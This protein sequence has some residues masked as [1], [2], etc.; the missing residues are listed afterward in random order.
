[1]DMRTPSQPGSGSPPASVPDGL[2]RELMQVATEA[3]IVVDSSHDI[4]MFNHGAEGIF[5][6][7]ADE[8]L[9][10]PLDVLLPSNMIGRHR[11]LIE[12]FS[13][14]ESVARSMGERMV[15]RA[16]R[17]DG[18]EFEGE[19]SIAQV[20][21]EGRR[22]FAAVLRDVTA[23]SRVQ[24]A[25]RSSEA[26]FRTLAESSPVGIF[27]TDTSG[28]C[29]YVN[30]RWCDIAGMDAD[31]AA[32]DGWL[33]GVHPDDRWMVHRAWVEAVASRSTF[34]GE[35]RLVGPGGR[36]SWVMSQAVPARLGETSETIFIGTV[37]DVTE[38]HEQTRAL[39]RARLEAE[40]A[41]RAKGMFLAN[42]SHE[43]RTP[44]NAVIGMTGLL[45]DTRITQ[46]QMDY[47]QTIRSSS[48][49]LLAII[50]DILDF[51]KADMGRIDLERQVFDLRRLIEDSM[52]LVSSDAAG[53]GLHLAYE[54]EQGVPE[55]IVGD[56][57]RLRQVLVN[58][59]SNAVKF[60]ENGEV[61]VR[62]CGE[63]LD[64]RRQRIQ[65]SVRD[66][67][68][69]IAE[70]KIGQLFQPFMQ[71]DATTTRR[72]GG[73]GLGLAISKRL[74]E[75]MGGSTWV[76]S[77]LGQG[78]TFHFAIEAE[79]A[80]GPD[81]SDHRAGAG[82]LSGRHVLI[83]DASQMQRQ[84]LMRLVLSWGM[85]PVA[86]DSADEALS[87]E[88]FEA[89]ID[90]AIVSGRLPE[91]ER[92]MARWGADGSQGVQG[93]VPVVMLSPVGSRPELT[94]VS[95]LR[96]VWIQTMPVRPGTL[97][98]NLISAV[99]EPDKHPEQPRQLRI[100]VAEDNAINQ[101]VTAHVLQRLGYRADVVANGREVLEATARQRYDAILMDLHMPEMDGMEAARRL[102]DRDGPGNAP[103]I[104]AMTANA[105]AGEGTELRASGIDACITKPAD[106]EAIRAALSA[107]AH[108]DR[109]EPPPA[110]VLDQG[111]IDYLRGLQDGDS[112]RLVGDLIGM[113]GADAPSRLEEI[114]VA[115]RTGHAEALW[116]SAHRFR[117]SAE[118]LGAARLAG[119]CETIERAAR[120]G[121]LDAARQAASG[122]RL[123]VQLV[124]RA[125]AEVA[126]RAG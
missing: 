123:E 7:R 69:G 78:S 21:S 119:L 108:R 107:V 48:E 41:A 105:L 75:L 95:A 46:E 27:Q 62:V 126:E 102:V 12:E 86:Y 34:R 90:V 30:E 110:G 116:R 20:E 38:L 39:E 28:G 40:T 53:K 37:V 47:A 91:L 19:A 31:Q 54:L 10:K 57:A 8:V 15:V 25:L 117:S 125:L 22:F 16:R 96:P 6:Y 72:Y 121:D 100:L 33:L 44:L 109:T 112:P 92:L 84:L 58:L 97:L 56:A 18:R 3:V 23:A 70:E 35:F 122:L 73:T 66:T 5:G 103:R 104:I 51:S 29:V 2:F 63:P 99:S 65:F 36:E 52:D 89:P 1:M 74:T 85:V 76:Q 50:N 106:L 11:T 82:V 59:L 71:A 14:S 17:A 49:A 118:N 32:G 93:R 94:P 13:R 24:Q 77:E 61:M 87:A 83:V 81:D 26:R 111:R 98:R 79:A 4:V 67:G 9:G 101:K 60:T 45:L 113:F 115:L 64:G 42:I 124:N 80:P 114:S 68:I 88:R 120:A 55:N 43:I